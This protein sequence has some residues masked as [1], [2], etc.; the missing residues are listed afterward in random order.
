MKWIE[1]NISKYKIIRKCKSWIISKFLI[2][3]KWLKHL[4]FLK[5][6]DAYLFERTL[7]IQRTWK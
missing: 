5:K 7:S 1:N 3:N 2:N 4:K 6:E